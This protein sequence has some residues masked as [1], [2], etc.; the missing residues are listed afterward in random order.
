MPACSVIQQD[1]L[2][3]EGRGVDRKHMMGSQ[4]YEYSAL[5]ADDARRAGSVVNPP[6]TGLVQIYARWWLPIARVAV[7]VAIDLIALVIAAVFA[8]GA[9]AHKILHQPADIYQVLLAFILMVPLG[10]GVAGL[11]PGFGLGAAEA[12]RRLCL[13]N[14]CCFLV[15]ADL[16]FLL[17]L[18]QHYSRVTLV[19]AFAASLLTVPTGR[20]L[21]ASMTEHWSWW[22]KPAI[23]VGNSTW[24]TA[25]AEILDRRRALGYRVIGVIHGEQFQH[26]IWTNGSDAPRS[27]AMLLRLA[28][29]GRCAVIIQQGTSQGA[30]ES[31]VRRFR[32]VMVLMEDFEGLPLENSRLLNFGNTMGLE[33]TNRLL[34]RRNR[35]FKRVLDIAVGGFFAILALPII[36]LTALLVLVFDGAPAFYCQQREGLG[37][38]MI[39][40]WKLRTMVRDSEARLQAALAADPA[41]RQEWLERCKLVRDPRIIPVIGTLLRRLSLD[42]LPQLWSVVKGEMSLVG[43]RPFPEYH[44]QLYPYEYRVLRRQVHPGLTGLTQV[45]VRSDSDVNE[46]RR[47]D[48]YYICNWSVWLDLYILARTFW[49][50][51]AS[52]GAY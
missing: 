26:E 4:H 43:P 29:Q 40:V 49:A 36:L 45:M 20:L 17:K 46:Q 9:W 12:F 41:L 48:T 10:Y 27:T 28:E 22:R 52:R 34:V 33:F 5:A 16:I 25:T 24:A 32:H 42:E 3:G 13:S 6:A 18:P 15:I 30:L 2:D 31:L 14:S 38:R 37:G 21:A 47:L 39:K 1:A 23:L 8:Y 11:Y 44:L 50:V 7:L 35:F 51:V 19:L